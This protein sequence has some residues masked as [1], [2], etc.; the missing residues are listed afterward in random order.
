MAKKRILFFTSTRADYGILRGLMSK[1]KDHPSFELLMLVSGAHL[2]SSSGASLVEIKKDEI[3][4]TECVEIN[5]FSNTGV[6]MAKS[7]GLA[8][9]SFSD[10]VSRLS[11]DIIELLGDRFETMAMSQVAMFLGIPVAHIHGGEISLG[12]IDDPIRH[13]IMKMSDLH[14]VTC[15]EHRERVIQLGEHPISSF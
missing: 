4:I 2:S 1:V 10:A 12:S 11:Q 5:L 8:I 9:I 6:G 3:P 7:T 15:K 14:F 13:S